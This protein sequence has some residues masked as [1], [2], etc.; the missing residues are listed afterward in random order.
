MVTGNIKNDIMYNGD[1]TKWKKLANTIHLL[2]ALRL[3]K[4][5]PVKGAAEFNKAMNNGNR[6][7]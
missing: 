4:V 3:S 6:Q 1:I 2:M 5:D 7:Y